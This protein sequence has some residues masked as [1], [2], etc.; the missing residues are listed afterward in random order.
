MTT[1][2]GSSGQSQEIKRLAT[3]KRGE[4][5]ELRVSWDEFTPEKGQPSR[6][7]SLRV[8]YEKDGEWR[9]TTKGITVRKPEL[10]AVRDALTRVIDGL[11][12]QGDTLPRQAPK[13]EPRAQQRPPA[14]SM[15]DPDDDDL[16]EECGRLF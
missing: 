15:S 2:N 13:S 3:I 1:H 7:V 4:T 8:W 12:R 16:A 11:A 6:Y 14:R 9:P 10:V 5:D